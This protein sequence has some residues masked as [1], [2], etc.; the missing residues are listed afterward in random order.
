M[1][2]V[3]LS[4]LFSVSS[5]AY[6]A[7]DYTI[8][9][10]HYYRFRGGDSDGNYVSGSQL[11]NQTTP[12]SDLGIP[13]SVSNNS[14]YYY[15]YYGVDQFSLKNTSKSIFAKKGYSLDFRL[16]NFVCREELTNS[17]GTTVKRTINVNSIYG[18]DVYLIGWNGESQK[19]TFPQSNF[20]QGDYGY[21]FYFKIDDV[22]FD[23][24]WFYVEIRY[25]EP[26]VFTP[27]L[28]YSSYPTKN[29]VGGFS[30]DSSLELYLSE[31]TTGLL[32]S[33]KEIVTNIK[34]GITE[35]PSKIWSFISDGLKALFVP[36]E[37]DMTAIKDDWDTLL[38]DRFGGLYQ[39]VQLIDDF[40]DTFNNPDA[41]STI[42]LPVTTV[43][44]AGTDFS[45]GG[46]DVQIVPTGFEFLITAIKTIISIVATCLFVNGLRNRFERI[47]GGEDD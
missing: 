27:D 5:Y 24:S 11:I 21:S 46:Y 20:K 17:S 14:Y 45:F 28:D 16:N 42:T 32:V 29:F 4:V 34:D 12:T 22:P 13:T 39:T 25:I 1:V 19:Y 43:N 33:I 26:Q 15:S 37:E 3:C 2:A 44:L 47:V 41:Q 35:L 18:F 30:S 31:A 23:V 40:A 8:Q 9:Y 38:S 6:A 10:Q 7:S 36:S